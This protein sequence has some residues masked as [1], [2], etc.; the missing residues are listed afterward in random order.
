MVNKGQKI[1]QE[2]K[3]LAEDRTFSDQLVKRVY[4]S[5]NLFQSF[6]KMYRVLYSRWLKFVNL[7][8]AG[9]SSSKLMRGI[10][11]QRANTES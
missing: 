2:I 6:P 5:T 10:F 4:I 1:L 7:F 8:Q 3:T 11:L 9:F